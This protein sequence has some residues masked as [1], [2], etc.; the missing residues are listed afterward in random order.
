MDFR[1]RDVEFAQCSPGAINEKTS[2]LG[3]LHSV[4]RA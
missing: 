3:Q 4:A 2:G 1:S